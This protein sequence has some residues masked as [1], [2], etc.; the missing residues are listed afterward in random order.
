MGSKV[1]RKSF[2]YPQDVSQRVS[3]SPI[4]KSDRRT[5]T[6]FRTVIDRGA[7][8]L[9]A[10]L[11]IY[12]ANQVSGSTLCGGGYSETGL[13]SLH[14]FK[15]IIYPHLP[16]VTIIQVSI[17]REFNFIV[18]PQL[19]TCTLIH[20]YVIISSSY[21]CYVFIKLLSG[22]SSCLLYCYDLR[23]ST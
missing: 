22:A 18:Y 15:F 17:T 14:E 2:L 23:V 7:C 8:H 20:V 5:Q 9:K 11:T 4:P 19:P 6:I 16:A 13:N 21:P 12:L 3:P 10:A 1:F